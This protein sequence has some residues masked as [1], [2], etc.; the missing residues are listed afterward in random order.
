MKLFRPTLL[1]HHLQ[2]QHSIQECRA[3]TPWPVR[4]GWGAGWGGGGAGTSAAT[5]M[6]W[7]DRFPTQNRQGRLTYYYVFNWQIFLMSCSRPV[8]SNFPNNELFPPSNE[9]FPPSD[10]LL[11][12]SNELFPPCNELLPPSISCSRPLMSCSCL[13]M[14]C[15][16]PQ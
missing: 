3:C 1:P 15:Y 14:S 11:P 2:C 6:C 16:R 13:L 12:P 8:M 10:E 5:T 4:W 9:L 7:S